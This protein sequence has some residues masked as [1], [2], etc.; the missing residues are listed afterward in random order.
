MQGSPA[1]STGSLPHLVHGFIRAIFSSA[2]RLDDEQLLM[3][4]AVVLLVCCSLMSRGLA[5]RLLASAR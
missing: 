4:R 3:L 5:C 1:C 2:L